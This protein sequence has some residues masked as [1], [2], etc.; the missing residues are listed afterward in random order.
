MVG[1]LTHI[2]IL[3]FA[4]NDSL[5]TKTI[6]TVFV[7]SQRISFAQT[8]KKTT[9]FETQNHPATVGNALQQSGFFLKQYGISGSATL[10]R[11]GSDAT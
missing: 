8:G 6:D 5:W 9:L 1:T 7:K 3:S 10:S 2:A 11:R 4:A